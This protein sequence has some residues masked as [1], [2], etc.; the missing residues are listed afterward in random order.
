MI[1]PNDINDTIK[2][3]LENYWGVIA[4]IKER[5]DDILFGSPKQ[6]YE[7]CIKKTSISDT[8]GFKAVQLTDS[9]TDDM[10]KWIK[11]INESYYYI[12]DK[13]DTKGELMR[14]IYFV[15]SPRRKSKSAIVDSLFISN[16]TYYNYLR[17]IMGVI[18]LKACKQKLIDI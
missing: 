5:R 8:T 17:E 12:R 6:D 14:L 4:T 2:W 9:D 1:L 7:V 16:D 11:V 15:K 13:D 18:A 10:I 3:Y